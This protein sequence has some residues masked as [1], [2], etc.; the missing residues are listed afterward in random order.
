MGSDVQYDHIV[1]GGGTAGVVVA[2]RLSEERDRRVLLLEAG[3]DYPDDTPAELLD[4]S[5]AVTT[6]NHN[7][8]LQAR[9]S[10]DAPAALTGQ[11]ARIARVFQVAASRLPPGQS[12][13][14]LAAAGERQ[15]A[16]VPY[17]LG[18]VMGGG[19]AI[20]GGLAL[21]ARPQDYAIWTEA[22]NDEWSWERVR[23]YI[24][25]IANEED[26]KPALPMEMVPPG[27]TRCQGAFLATCLELGYPQVDIRRGTA[28]GV[29][30]VPKSIRAGRRVSTAALYLAAARKRP[31]L[32]LEPRCLVDRLILEHRDGALT[33]TGVEALAGGRRC[34]FAGGQIVL[35]AGAINS[36]AILLRSGIGAAEEIARVGGEPL[37]DLPGVGKNLQDHP[38]VSIWAAPREGSCPLG[39]T[40]HQAVLQLRSA[41]SAALCDLQIFMLS[42]VSTRRLPALRDV[43]GSEVAMGLSVVVATPL[44][45]GRVELLD[46][47][48]A[49]NPRIYLNCM[50][51]TADLRRMKEG[52]RSAWRI[53]SGER[54]ARH[55][56]RVVLWS[57]S[58]IDSDPLLESLI[59]STARVT[60]H[61]VGTLRMGREDDAMAVV[62]QRGRLYGC[63]N[64][65]VADAS[66]MPA[67]PSVPTNLTC[68]LIGERIAAHLRGV[69]DRVLRF[70]GAED[71]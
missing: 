71:E 64:I 49:S 11:Q 16:S 2:A 20:N 19:S 39:E 4:V 68:M 7:W 31:N 3:P 52:L 26:E 42:A 59:R 65:T 53:L 69:G 60:W 63:N 67:I 44:S 30:A 41:A 1:V 58:I 46:R 70:P 18:K 8:D 23:P 57:Q 43:V 17:P 21:H 50:R 55:I 56:E 66:I 15:A 10:E 45:R 25:R 5:A 62:D 51:E 37:L 13:P 40:V 47:D 29:G 6:G 54:L 34:R 38:A 12:L 48:P 28:C 14:A 22:G 32:T 36:P 61:P 33:A 24:E 35:A 27:F 9:L